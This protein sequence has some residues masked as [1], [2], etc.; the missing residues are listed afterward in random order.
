[1]A[2]PNLN[3]DNV[4]LSEKEKSA[5]VIAWHCS[6][7]KPDT[8]W[9][10]LASI[11]GYTNIDS[12]KNLVRAADK[13]LAAAL[14]AEGQVEEPST[15]TPK[16][17]IATKGKRKAAKDASADAPISKKGKTT[18]AEDEGEDEGEDSD[19]GEI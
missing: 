16:K 19:S 12:V 8:D 5:L 7:S 2:R 14:V 9:K 6:P 10:K 13:K 3:I 17:R 4:G 1:M 18:T 11:G 15:S